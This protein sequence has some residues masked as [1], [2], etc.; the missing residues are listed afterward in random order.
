M[1]HH[2]PSPF[3]AGRFLP[4]SG[5]SYRTLGQFTTVTGR[6][7]PEGGNHGYVTTSDTYTASPYNTQLANG[8]GTQRGATV[9][10]RNEAARILRAA[11]LRD[12]LA[13]VE[14]WRRASG[15]DRVWWRR[16]A[17][18]RLAEWRRLYQRP[19]RAAFQAA[20]ARNKRRAA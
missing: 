2:P 17:R 3:A 7:F 5:D 8:N 4:T 1:Y 20:V 18:H 14:E 15:P 19:E 10:I 16:D 11:R 9:A 12:L 6:P 13:A